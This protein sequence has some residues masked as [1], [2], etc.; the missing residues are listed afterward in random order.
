MVIL[1][2]PICYSYN[3]SHKLSV[4]VRLTFRWS[5]GFEAKIQP[6][7]PE[8]LWERACA[9]ENA[10]YRANTDVM[11]I[12]RFNNPLDINHTNYD[13]SVVGKDSLHNYWFPKQ[14]NRPVNNTVIV[15]TTE[16]NVVSLAD[17]GRPWKDPAAGLWP[18]IVEKI[19]QQGYHVETVDY[20]TPIRDLLNRLR[21]A[22]G[23]VGYHGTAAWPAKFMHTPS[24]LFANGGS[25]TSNA[26][27]YAEIIKNINEWESVIDSIDVYFDG[28]REKINE[29]AARYKA[30][31]PN[32]QFLEHLH[33]D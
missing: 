25:L 30:Y 6:R 27:C 33:H 23:F 16:D 32:R 28:S 29:T 18:Q 26:F 15:N 11:I 3:I 24:I 1:F 19:K 5:V 9:I 7:D 12:H 4:P 22:V 2:P 17:Y 21:D 13:W 14:R 31:M 20:R 10:C 8:T